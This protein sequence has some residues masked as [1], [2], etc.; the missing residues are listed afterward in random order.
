MS[1]EQLMTRPNRTHVSDLGIIA[2]QIKRLEKQTIGNV[3]E[4]GRLLSEA[5]T[6]IKHGDWQPW[7]RANFEWSLRTATRFIN[8][9]Q[10]SIE[11]DLSALNISLSALY[12][13]ADLKSQGKRYQIVEA[14]KT[15]RATFEI[16]QS[17]CSASGEAIRSGRIAD[18]KQRGIT[19]ARRAEPTP[20]EVIGSNAGVKS[21]IRI[22]LNNLKSVVS[23]PIEP[24]I[25][26]TA[27][28]EP[29]VLR[30]IIDRLERIYQARSETRFDADNG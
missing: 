28:I 10:L 25:E 15:R 1:A 18:K 27:E 22:A 19:S 21:R 24:W 6:L 23:F 9:Y 5:R 11:M 3:I 29:R 30:S 20:H 7:L 16:A 17:I 13:V 14:A 2:D 4:T 8:V 26:A 12:L